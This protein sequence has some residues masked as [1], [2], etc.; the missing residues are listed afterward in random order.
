ML[1]SATSILIMGLP[2]AGKT[3]LAKQLQREL[4]ATWFNADD[5]RKSLNDWDFSNKGRLRQSQRMHNLCNSAS[6]EYAIA[7][8]IAPTE[9]CRKAFNA[10]WVVWVDTVLESR[11]ADTNKLFVPPTKYDFRITERNA[12]RWADFI[13][14]HIKGNI[15]RPVFDWTKETVQMLGRW[16]PWHKG[17]RALFDRAIKKT[18]QVAIQVR[19]CCGLNSSNPFDFNIVKDFINRDLEPIYQGQYIVQL[20]PNITN[21]TYGRKVGYSVTEEVFDA[22][23]QSISATNIRQE[24]GLK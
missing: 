6:S 7:D 3:T 8:F 17:H 9:D 2:G 21:I 23:V 13:A 19:G 11:F 14:K 15:K 5:V 4:S 20:V 12:T 1:G 22:D 16:Q 24:M 18:G 10:D